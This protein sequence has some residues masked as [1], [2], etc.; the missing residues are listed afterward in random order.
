MR[1]MKPE[2]F[3]NSNPMAGDSSS[4]GVSDFTWAFMEPAASQDSSPVAADNLS[5]SEVQLLTSRER[6]LM[7]FQET[8]IYFVD[9]RN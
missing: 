1:R 9:L 5:N 7:K 3:G 6:C 4:M 2:D 8:K